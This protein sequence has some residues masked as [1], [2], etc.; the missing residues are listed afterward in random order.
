MRIAAPSN[1]T[2]LVDYLVPLH[3]TSESNHRGSDWWAWVLGLPLSQLFPRI[4]HIYN[5]NCLWWLL[6]C[7][8]SHHAWPRGLRCWFS[9]DAGLRETP[10]VMAVTITAVALRDSSQLCLWSLPLPR[11]TLHSAVS[12]AS[13]V[14]LRCSLTC[15]SRIFRTIILKVP[16]PFFNLAIKL[17]TFNSTLTQFF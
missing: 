8:V 3:C 10:K 17:T 9:S 7:T 1:S 2:L 15:F 6:L 12:H 14:P 13:P 4:I 5:D 11:T 16:L